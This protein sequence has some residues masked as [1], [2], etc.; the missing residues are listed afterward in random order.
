M[1]RKTNMHWVKAQTLNQQQAGII[2]LKEILLSAFFRYVAFMNHPNMDSEKTIGV[3]E[4]T[5]PCVWN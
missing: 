5:R 4:D 3:R 1:I 2:R